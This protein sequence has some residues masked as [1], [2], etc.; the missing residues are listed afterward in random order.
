MNSGGSDAS[1]P[2]AAGWL[3]G[4]LFAAAAVGFG[5]YS[6]KE[7]RQALREAELTPQ[8]EEALRQ[9]RGE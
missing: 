2:A 6:W 5:L 7:Y 8:E 3:T 9:D 1:F 4:A